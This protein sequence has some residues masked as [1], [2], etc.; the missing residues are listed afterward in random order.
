MTRKN[1]YPGV[2]PHL[3]S[4]LQSPDG[5]WESFHA[6]YINRL[7]DLLEEVLPENYYSLVEKSLQV[8]ILD[9]GDDPTEV[10]ARTRPDVIVMRGGQLQP[11]LSSSQQRVPTLRLPIVEEFDDENDFY[12]LVIYQLEGK[13]LPG[14]PVTRF[15]VLS[16]GNKPGGSHHSQY[17]NNR[18]QTLYSGLRMVEI[19]F[20][21]ERR[22]ILSKIP[23]YPEDVPE[24]HPYYII[25]TDPRPT[26]YEGMNDI[27]GFGVQEAIPSLPVPLDG[28]DK[29]ET[30]FGHVYNTVIEKRRGFGILTD[31][32]KPPERFETYSPQDQQYIL[33]RMAEIA[34]AL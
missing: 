3:N 5:G 11:T 20:L 31:Y 33:R 13:K 24:A 26:I 9:F 22:P 29:V 10:R 16:P 8:G 15:E 27:Y 2:N 7:A 14:V 12:G 18:S 21:H 23:V 25:I 30:D 32:T 19:D 6:E 34:A 4:L 28:D 17:M 1:L